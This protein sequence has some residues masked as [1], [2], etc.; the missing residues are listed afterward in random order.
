NSKGTLG[1][2]RV[3]AD[4]FGK[5]TVAWSQ[6]K[7]AQNADITAQSFVVRNGAAQAIG[8]PSTFGSI[9][10][11]PQYQPMIAI[12]AQGDLAAAWTTTNADR[13]EVDTIHTTRTARL[14]VI[15]VAG[16]S[17]SIA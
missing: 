2:P 16:D 13:D 9:P 15:R 7:S 12:N 4:G 6:I 8:A 14:A 3:A 5:F 11:T 10:A 17:N 1:Q